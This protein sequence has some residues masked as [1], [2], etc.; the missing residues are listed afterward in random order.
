MKVIGKPDEGELHVRFD[1]GGAGGIENKKKEMRKPALHSTSGIGITDQ[2]AHAACDTSGRV[3]RT[4]T[5]ANHLPGSKLDDFEKILPIRI[6]IKGIIRDILE[7][8]AG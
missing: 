1:E 7:I 5:E 3:L 6:W 4:D 2:I 8:S